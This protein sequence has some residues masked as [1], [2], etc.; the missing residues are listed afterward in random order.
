[1]D[2]TYSGPPTHLL[3][4]AQFMERNIGRVAPFERKPETVP[5]QLTQG[6]LD[7]I[8]EKIGN[9]E[10]GIRELTGLQLRNGIWR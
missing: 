7:T 8:M 1:M 4:D 5:V 2:K 3:I 6:D 9:I 10:K